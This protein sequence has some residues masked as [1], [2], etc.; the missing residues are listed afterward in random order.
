MS[1]TK[2]DTS[3][4]KHVATN[5]IKGAELPEDSSVPLVL[6]SASRGKEDSTE[7]VLPITIE[8]YARVSRGAGSRCRALRNG[9]VGLS[10]FKYIALVQMPADK[11]SKGDDNG[12]KKPIVTGFHCYPDGNYIESDFSHELGR[13]VPDDAAIVQVHPDSGEIDIAA[14]PAVLKKDMESF[15]KTLEK[16]TEIDNSTTFTVNGTVYSVSD[17]AGSEV[18]FTCTRSRV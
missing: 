15:I 14:F 5:L 18:M 1:I 6:F 2:K 3:S 9:L 16:M 8:A 13:P 17:I 4:L 12:P 11:K 7:V 10:R